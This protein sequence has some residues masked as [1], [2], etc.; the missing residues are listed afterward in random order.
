MIIIEF[1]LKIWKQK[2]VQMGAII[3]EEKLSKNVTHVF[4]VNSDSLRKKFGQKLSQR[5][6]GVLRT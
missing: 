3:E 2:L 6:K 5:F 4:A 1:L